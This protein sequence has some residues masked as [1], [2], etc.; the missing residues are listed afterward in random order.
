MHI[1]VPDGIF[2]AWIWIGSIVILVPLLSIALFIVRK[3]QKRLVTTSA[4]TALMLIVFS[5][6][7]FG[8][9]LN[10]TSLCGILLGPWWSL[11][12]ITVTNAFLAL[13]GHGGVTVAPINILLNWTEAIIGWILFTQVIKRFHN[14]NARSMASGAS[15]LFALS[16]SFILFLGIILLTGLNPAAALE[17]E[18]TAAQDVTALQQIPLREFAMI[19]I[20]PLLI[21]AIIEAILTASIMRFIYR[22]RPRLL[23]Q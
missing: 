1:H 5:V 12:S 21:G 8:F 17:H 14:T 23:Q 10:F 15:V 11:I 7:V 19:S 13:F 16:I 2:P 9:H 22:T 20:I 4:L 6:E 18:G 3:D